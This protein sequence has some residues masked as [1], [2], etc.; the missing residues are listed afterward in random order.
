MQ[1]HCFAGTTR[2]A[3]RHGQAGVFIPI[4][5]RFGLIGALGNWVIDKASRQT[6][7]WA[8]DGLTCEITESVA[9][10][11]PECT[12]AT[13]KR[14]SAVGVKPPID[15]FGTGHSSPSHLRKLSAGELKIDSSFVRRRRRL[16]RSARRTSAPRSSST[17]QAGEVG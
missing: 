14:L 1:G 4:A 9:M 15:D 2:G 8:D 6:R 3:A 11:D 16:T 5:E 12:M 10:D 7:A 17:W 13:F